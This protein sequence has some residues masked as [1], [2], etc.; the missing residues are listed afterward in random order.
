MLIRLVA[1]MARSDHGVLVRIGSASSRDA[2]E[3]AK[4]AETAGARAVSLKL[5]RLPGVGYRELYR[6]VDHVCRAVKIPVL[7]HT[8]K[9]DGLESLQMEEFETLVNYKGLQGVLAPQAASDEILRWKKWF[10]GRG[11][12]VLSGCSLSIRATYDAGACG[13]VCGLYALAP[14][15]A[16]ALA[17]AYRQGEKAQI[18]KLEKKWSAARHLLGP[19]LRADPPAGLQKIAAKIAKRSL[20]DK[21]LPTT[22]PAPL[23]KAALKLQGHGIRSE[24]R[25][26]LET[27]RASAFDAFEAQLRKVG[28][29]S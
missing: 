23:I 20:E 4:V 6:H 16:D 25:P 1:Q 12:A 7:L 24:V 18:K 28:V 11:G 19:R 17:S 10:D 29:L 26:P 21:I 5:P 2:G 14:E 15:A 9:G 13:L 3:L 8:Q 22:Y 27:L